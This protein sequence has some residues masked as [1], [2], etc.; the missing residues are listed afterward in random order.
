V[1]LSDGQTH[2]V[3]ETIGNAA[4]T[5]RGEGGGVV[6]LSLE[7]DPEETKRLRLVALRA[8]VERAGARGETATA[9]KLRRSGSSGLLD[10]FSAECQKLSVRAPRK[11]A[12]VGVLV[13]ESIEA[14]YLV[15]GPKESPR[16]GFSLVP[17]DAVPDRKPPVARKF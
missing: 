1:T 3:F 10:D 5:R 11:N 9:T 12:E 7:L 8:T 2:W 4:V 13:N 14:G 17:G 15:R 16:G 6:Q